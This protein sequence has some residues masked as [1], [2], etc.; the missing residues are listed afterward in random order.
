[1]L[2]AVVLLNHLDVLVPDVHPGHILLSGVD[3]GMLVLEAGPVAAP[4]GGHGHAGQHEDEGGGKG[5]HVARW[6][7]Y[8]DSM[9]REQ[10]NYLYKCKTSYFV[11]FD[12]VWIMSLFIL[13]DRS[14]Y[15]VTVTH[16]P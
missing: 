2:P 9:Q 14:D 5:R 1:M 11:L 12:F 7:Q 6:V 13:S 4:A 15:S 10:N 8:S 3:L 16:E